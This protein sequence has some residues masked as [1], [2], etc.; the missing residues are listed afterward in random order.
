MRSSQ[1]GAL[2]LL[3]VGSAV[4]LAGCPVSTTFTVNTNQDLHDTNV[5]D[6]QCIANAGGDLCSLRAAIEQANAFTPGTAHIVINVP[7]ATYNLSAE[8]EVHLTINSGRFVELVGASPS[9]TIIQPAE[10]IFS[11]AFHIL[12]G[13]F[14]FSNLTIRNAKT[15]SNTGGG[16]LVEA[17]SFYGEVNNCIIEENA[18]SFQGGGIYAIGGGGASLLLSDTIIRNNETGTGGAGGGGG[19][20]AQIGYVALKRVT[21]SGNRGGNG[22]GALLESEE[23][24]ILDSAIIENNGHVNASSQPFPGQGAGLEVDSGTVFI[25]RSTISGNQAGGHG[26]G[27]FVVGDETSLTLRDVTISNNAVDGQ[28]GAGGVEWALLPPTIRIQNSILA[29]NRRGFEASDCHPSVTSNGHNF[30]GSDL[31]CTIENQTNDQ[32]GTGEAPLDPHLQPL[33]LNGGPTM[34]HVPDAESPVIDAG[35]GCDTVDQRGQPRPRDGDNNTVAA[36]D[37]GAVEWQ[38]GVEPVGDEGGSVGRQPK[39]SQ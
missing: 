24:E 38:P 5:G 21:V 4:F 35:S 36:C 30:I 22:A 3:M 26:G 1:T 16:I 20:Y 13:F 7:V 33:A 25:G 18:S 12:G 27:I 8:P 9:G 34:N 28:Q 19:L 17:P 31:N 11:R 14:R 29:E 10:G 37:I 23:V 6:L 2:V 39:P 32:I 15:N